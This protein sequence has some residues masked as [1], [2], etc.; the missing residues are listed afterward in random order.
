MY[1]HFKKGE[2][3]F[4][5][6]SYQ[7]FSG[8]DAL[9]VS[10]SEK[11][12]AQ[13]SFKK[14][15]TPL[16]R[17]VTNMIKIGLCTLGCRV[18]QYETRAISEYLEEHGAEIGKFSEVCDAYIVNT[19]AVTAESERKSRQM[20]RRASK[21][22][23]N[24]VIIITGCASQLDPK[25]CAALP[26]VKYVCGNED[27]LAAAKAVFELTNTPI[28]EPVIAKMTFSGDY[29]NYSVKHPDH[30]RAYVKIEDGCDNKCAYCVINKVRGPVRSKPFDDVIKEVKSVVALGY[31]EIVL[32]GIETCSYQ[33]GLTALMRELCKIDGLERLR[34]SS[35]NPA[36]INKKFTDATKDLEKVCPH[37]HLSLQSGCDKTLAAMR[38]RYNTRMLTENC[39]YLRESIK[40]VCF[41]ADIICGFPGETDEDFQ[42]TLST[43]RSLGLLS[44]HVFPFSK[45]P[46]T[47]AA[48]MPNQV[49]EDIKQKRCSA[50]SET[51]AESQKEII[52]TYVET[53][54]PFKVLFETYK[55]GYVFGHTENFISVRA[56]GEQKYLNG[57]FNVI[58]TN[59]A[60][61]DDDYLANAVIIQNTI[62]Y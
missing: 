25:L 41:T 46:G 60:N 28:I 9:A 2:P 33:F 57:V 14:A 26:G 22:N 11:F 45:R 62:L 39:K 4:S 38:R 36:F 23:P 1:A 56:K 15:R 17:K 47:E 16:S 40:D 6:K 51:V 8:I 31:K 30:T 48:S 27:K 32:T 13:L 35:V 54:K 50:L 29:E 20:A 43:V 59:M 5:K 3:L 34:L 21:L 37:F 58:L 52:T 61:E 24:A 49:A 18:N 10:M 19:C 42:T 7:I 44:A 55:N 12:F 53:Q